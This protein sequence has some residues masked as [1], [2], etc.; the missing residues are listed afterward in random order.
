MAK[1]AENRELDFY[2]HRDELMRFSSECIV[3]LATG[4]ERSTAKRLTV[5]EMLPTLISEAPMGICNLFVVACPTSVPSGRVT[6][7]T[8]EMTPYVISPCGGLARA[9][10]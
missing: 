8:D 1:G 3:H 10:A 5:R 6:A 7:L 4:L 9:R 2:P